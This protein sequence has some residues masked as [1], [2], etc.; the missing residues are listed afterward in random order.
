MIDTPIEVAFFVRNNI[1][2]FDINEKVRQLGYVQ[3]VLDASR[4]MRGE[5]PLCDFD[6]GILC[7][8]DEERKEHDLMVAKMNLASN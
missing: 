2:Q 6:P 7:I 1:T 5:K 3:G 8:S 4:V